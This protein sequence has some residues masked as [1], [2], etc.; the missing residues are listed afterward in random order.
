MPR[1]VR[2]VSTA[3]FVTTSDLLNH[4]FPKAPATP[5]HLSHECERAEEALL[6]ATL[7]TCRTR[8]EA[9]ARL[10]ALTLTD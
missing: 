7:K 8:D 9:L 10:L 2:R 4:A 6:R 3:R 1:G 5:D